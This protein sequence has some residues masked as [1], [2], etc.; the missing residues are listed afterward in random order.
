M[1]DPRIAQANER[2]LLAWVRTGIGLMAFGF[3]IARSGDWIRLLTDRDPAGLGHL[4]WIGVALVGLGTVFPILA[5][6]QF[7]RVRR[8]IETDT[9][10]P[11]GGVLGPALALIIGLVGA[12]LAALLIAD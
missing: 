8:A 10:I 9:A 4:G 7:R 2:T 5:T 12:A 11:T 1:F 3:V 6:W